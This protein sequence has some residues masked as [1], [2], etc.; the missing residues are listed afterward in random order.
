MVC[1]KER[2]KQKSEEK[3]LEKPDNMYL[4]QYSFVEFG[5]VIFVLD[6]LH[7]FDEIC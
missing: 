7:V 3:I 6:S 5:V 1:R 4:P 2:S